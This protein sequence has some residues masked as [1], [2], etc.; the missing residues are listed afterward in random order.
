MDLALITYLI[1]HKTKPNQIL[2][3]TAYILFLAVREA[4][5]PIF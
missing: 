4:L 1:C 5:K 3:T 2:L